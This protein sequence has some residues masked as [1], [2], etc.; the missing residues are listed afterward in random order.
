M[1]NMPFIGIFGANPREI[2]PG[3]L[4]PPLEGVVVH[5]LGCQ[6]EVA[7]ALDLIAQ[8]PDHLRV[9][10]IAPLAD[11]DVAAGQLKRSVW[12]DA[13]DH[14]DRALQIEQRRDLDQT[15]DRDHRKDSNDQDDR[16]LFENLM[17]RPE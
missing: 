14:L 10:E 15:A 4:R 2:R 5:A 17:S 3:S 16:I 11:V 6:L 8:W 7:V 9:A 1:R 13:I 12:P